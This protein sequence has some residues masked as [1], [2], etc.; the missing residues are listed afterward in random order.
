M[1]QKPPRFETEK[2]IPGTVSSS[3]DVG[4]VMNIPGTVSNQTNAEESVHGFAPNTLVGC[5][6]KGGAATGA[7][8]TGV[9]EAAKNPG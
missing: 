9:A 8:T 4:E 6:A 3:K 7:P 1:S 2:A 5:G